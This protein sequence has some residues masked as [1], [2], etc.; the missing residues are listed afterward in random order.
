MVTTRRLW[1]LRKE[2]EEELEGRLW[3]T[4]AEER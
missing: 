4:L 1:L 3:S 2:E